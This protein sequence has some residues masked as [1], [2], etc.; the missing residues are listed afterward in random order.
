MFRFFFFLLKIYVEFVFQFNLTWLLRPFENY[1]RDVG[2]FS[3]PLATTLAI[4]YIYVKILFTITSF[5]ENLKYHRKKNNNNGNGDDFSLL[6]SSLCTRHWVF[7]ESTTSYTCCT[8]QI[9]NK[10]L[11]NWIPAINSYAFENLNGPNFKS[12]VNC[13]SG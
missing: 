10:T 2:P 12:K 9:Q 3:S 5:I 11:N 1:A 13:W 4:V 7:N 8:D 6:A